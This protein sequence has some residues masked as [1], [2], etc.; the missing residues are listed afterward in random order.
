MSKQPTLGHFKFTKTVSHRGQ[1]VTVDLESE[2]PTKT[3]KCPH[4]DMMFVNK[5][6]LSIHVKCKHPLAPSHS[7]SEERSEQDTIPTHESTPDLDVTHVSTSTNLVEPAIGTAA[8]GVDVTPDPTESVPD[9]AFENAAETANAAEEGP[10]TKRLGSLKRHSYSLSVK[11]EAIELYETGLSQEQVN[12]KSC[13][14]SRLF[15]SKK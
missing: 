10:Q 1:A 5:Q 11:A 15:S 8:S 9:D 14:L 7:L 3:L 12:H 6:G 13:K 4:C 2:P